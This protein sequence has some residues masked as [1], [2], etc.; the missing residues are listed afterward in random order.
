MELSKD[1]CGVWN[2][3]SGLYTDVSTLSHALLFNLQIALINQKVSFATL[4][5]S[6]ARSYMVTTLFLRALPLLYCSP[7]APSQLKL[8][9]FP[10]H[11]PCIMVSLL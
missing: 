5:W 8:P 6:S 1:A 9:S 3:G 10:L 4:C 2:D 7:L 11:I